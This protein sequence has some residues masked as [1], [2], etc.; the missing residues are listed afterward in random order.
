VSIQDDDKAGRDALAKCPKCGRPPMLR[1]YDVRHESNLVYVG[2]IP[3]GRTEGST[4]TTYDYEC[5][6]VSA[7]VRVT[8]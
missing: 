5:C 6:G 4:V 2:G 7:M 8:S 1:S 3:Q